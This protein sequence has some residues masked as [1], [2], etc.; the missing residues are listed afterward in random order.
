[1][2]NGPL[3]PFVVPSGPLGPD[4]RRTG[5]MG[6]PGR[7]RSRG[8]T[9]DECHPTQSSRFT[10]MFLKWTVLPGSWACNANV[11]L[12]SLRVKS[13]PAFLSSGSV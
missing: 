8:G 5:I 12:S 10:R 13:S 9:A 6:T 11:P 3:G 2:R 7:L 1:M 4:Y